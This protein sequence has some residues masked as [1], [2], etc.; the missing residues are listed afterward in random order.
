MRDRHSESLW[1]LG[2][3]IRNNNLGVPLRRDLTCTDLLWSEV[4]GT[5]GDA[6]VVVNYDGEDGKGD[7]VRIELRD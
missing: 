3:A 4:S 6:W 1:E 2:I 7:A 5:I